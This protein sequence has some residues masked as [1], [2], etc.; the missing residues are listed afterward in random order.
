MDKTDCWKELCKGLQESDF[1][2]Q[3]HIWDEISYLR[4]DFPVSCN[5]NI[6]KVEARNSKPA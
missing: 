1:P 4:K 5:F 6:Q 3:I 2:Q